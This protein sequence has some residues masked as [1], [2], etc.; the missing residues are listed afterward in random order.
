MLPCD[1]KTTSSDTASAEEVTCKKES[2]LSIL[3]IEW[4]R[5]YFSFLPKE[6]PACEKTP[7]SI[8]APLSRLVRVL[9]SIEHAYRKNHIPLTL[10]LPGNVYF[11]CIQEFLSSVASY[12]GKTF[13]NPDLEKLIR[14]SL[15]SKEKYCSSTYT[16]ILYFLAL[17]IAKGESES[18][19]HEKL[20]YDNWIITVEPMKETFEA[21]VDLLV[22]VGALRSLICSDD[23]PLLVQHLSEFHRSWERFGTQLVKERKENYHCFCPGLSL[24]IHLEYLDDYYYLEERLR[25]IKDYIDNFPDDGSLVERYIDT[26]PLKEIAPGTMRC[27]LTAQK[28]LELS[29]SY[30][31]HVVEH[32]YR[33]VKICNT[34]P[35]VL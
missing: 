10:T 17:R 12:S 24:S 4:I 14:T 34:T 15:T 13:S 21:A 18:F 3:P 29:N 11:E 25:K 23:E 33:E 9:N 7:S 22:R 1:S 19:I 31:T 20:R 28:A 27:Y 5:S 35:P 16:P 26:I 6:K 8:P 32:F 2:L 30:L